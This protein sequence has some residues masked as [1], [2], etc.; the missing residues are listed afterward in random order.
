MQLGKT[1]ARVAD[2]AKAVIEGMDAVLD[3]VRPGTTAEAVEAAWRKVIQRYGLKKESRIGYSI[4][5]AYPPDWGEHTIS[6]RPGDKTALQ[7]G[8][9]LHSILGMWMDG[10]GIEISET[11]LVTETGHE[12]LTKFPRDIHVKSWPVS[13]DGRHRDPPDASAQ[14]WIVRRSISTTRQNRTIDRPDDSTIAA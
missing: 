7:P 6:L 3:A 11:I 4:G 13:H 9:V 2:T 14:Y 1:P 10:W 8:N 12:T 5:V